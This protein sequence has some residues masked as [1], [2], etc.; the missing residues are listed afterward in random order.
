MRWDESPGLFG[1]GVG[2][3]TCGDFT[4]GICGTEHNKG[5]DAAEDYSGDS[6][7]F[8]DFAGIEICENCFETIETEIL[9]R[10]K[11]ILPWYRRIVE[12]RRES[13]DAADHALKAVGA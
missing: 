3:S 7:G 1:L 4:C 11:H 12:R 9:G 2:T 8:E 5:N 13:L 10:M 6:V